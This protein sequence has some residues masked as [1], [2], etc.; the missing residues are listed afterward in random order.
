MTV[1]VN[2]NDP[3][4]NWYHLLY[5]ISLNGPRAIGTTGAAGNLG[6]HAGKVRHQN[7]SRA[8]GRSHDWHNYIYSR[9]L[10]AQTAQTVLFNDAPAPAPPRATRQRPSSRPNRWRRQ[11]SLPRR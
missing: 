2:R 4:L 3:A 9:G 8:V 5:G 11:V 6:P 7:V 10:M 1:M